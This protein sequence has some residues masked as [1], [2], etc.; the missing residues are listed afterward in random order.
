[1][2]SVD[3]RLVDHAYEHIRFERRPLLDADGEEVE[4][5]C[6][7]GIV[8]DNPDELNSYTTDTVKEVILAFREVSS[9]PDVVAAVFTGTGDRAFCT[10]GNTREYS[11]H[12]AGR[13]A[14]YSAYMGLF[15]DMVS[16][17]L[18]CDE[19]QF[20]ADLSVWDAKITAIQVDSLSN[21]FGG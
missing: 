21:V 4:G 8:L 14:E 12:Y 1:M 3:H 5:R 20:N 19:L 17:I 11:E 15:N 6:K 10:G 2:E 13:P 18:E 7:R 16:A 9:E